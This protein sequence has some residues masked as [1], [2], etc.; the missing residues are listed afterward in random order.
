MLIGPGSPP[1]PN[2]LQSTLLHRIGRVSLW[3]IF[4]GMTHSPL[5]LAAASLAL[6]LAACSQPS[7]P[8]ESATPAAPEPP[9]FELPKPT[10]VMEA[11]PA[12]PFT[13]W[14]PEGATI[15]NHPNVP[16]LWNAFVDGQNVATYY[17]DDCRASDYQRFVGANADAV[18]TPPP[19]VEV[20]LS[21]ETCPVNSD[22]RMNRMNVIF[23][24]ASRTVTK[25]AC[26]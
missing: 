25:I 20:R 7:T 21:C 2:C 12:P 17:G 11:D 13:Y 6:I 24:E 1:G 16:G 8:V 5:R 15:R 4:S 3:S 18:P 9:P 26:Y 14:A 22:L 10:V 19:P 23:E